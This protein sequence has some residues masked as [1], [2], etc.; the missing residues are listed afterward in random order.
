MHLVITETSL[1]VSSHTTAYRT[2][3][4]SFRIRKQPALIFTAASNLLTRVPQ[5]SRRDHMG[6]QGSKTPVSFY[7]VLLWAVLM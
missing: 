2:V 7:R 3:A 1:L 6:S 4:S 5:T